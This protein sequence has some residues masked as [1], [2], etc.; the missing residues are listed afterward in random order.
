MTTPQI[1]ELAAFVEHDRLVGGIFGAQ[2]DT[3]RFA[4]RGV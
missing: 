2:F 1:D 3:G 4:N